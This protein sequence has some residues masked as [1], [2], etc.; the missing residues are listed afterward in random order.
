MLGAAAAVLLAAAGC[1]GKAPLEPDEPQDGI[2]LSISEIDFAEKGGSQEV[3]VTSTGNWIMNPVG[4]Y[5]WVTASS[6]SGSDGDCV[7]FTAEE[8]F[9]VDKKAEFVFQTARVRT[10]LTIVSHAGEKPVIQLVSPA[11]EILDHHSHQLVV[12]MKSVLRYRELKYTLSKDAASWVK[13]RVTLEGEDEHEALFNFDISPLEGLDDR[14]TVITF[15]G[16]GV[17]CV[18]V[19]LVQKA[20]S[21]L[22]TNARYYKSEL[23]GGE[24]AV[25]VT[26]NVTYDI[27]VASDG[28]GWCTYKENR[29]GAEIFQI[30]PSEGSNRKT[31]VVF[32]QNNAPEGVQPLRV[33]FTIAQNN[34]LIFW[35]LDMDRARVFPQWDGSREPGIQSEFTLEALFHPKDLNKPAGGIS[36]IMGIEE[37]FI[38]RLG[39][40]D[41][42]VNQIQVATKNDKLNIP[43][44]IKTDEWYHIAV[45]FNSGNVHVYLDG[46]D[47]GSADF[48][49]KEVNLSP[50]WTYETSWLA[51]RSFWYGYSFDDTRGFNGLMTE[52]RIWTRA[53]SSEEINGAD[54]FYDVDPASEGLACYWKMEKVDGDRIPDKTTNGNNLFGEIAVENYGSACLGDP[55]FN[56]VAVT[57]PLK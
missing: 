45:T 22:Q 55:G 8:N 42:P 32:L 14:E 10:V 30:A 9:D 4:N 36:T 39:D 57:L 37:V 27:N 52:L 50:K 43:I 44:D 53:L 7:T 41:V 38:V 6:D 3:K 19:K 20:E 28:D 47:V 29:N 26:S 34:T 5:D 18:E 31:E 25:S 54:H 16:A 21:C 24:I 40:R 12:K 35:A 33:S 49:V 17:G 13:Y 1:T 48:S 2:S 15:S 51:G 11:E 56:W 23:E 46:K